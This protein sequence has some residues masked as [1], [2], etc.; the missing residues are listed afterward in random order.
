MTE[1][2]TTRADDGATWPEL[3]SGLGIGQLYKIGVSQQNP[4]RT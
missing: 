4:M 3:S 1:A 2:Y